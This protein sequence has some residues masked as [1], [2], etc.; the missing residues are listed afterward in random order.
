MTVND[1]DDDE[2]DDDDDDNDDN[3]N[4]LDTISGWL[5][6][7]CDKKTWGYRLLTSTMSICLKGS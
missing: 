1:N 4:K 5:H 3:N 7:L 2:D 6:P